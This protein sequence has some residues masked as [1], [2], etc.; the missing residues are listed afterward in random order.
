M[1]RIVDLNEVAADR[2]GTTVDEAVGDNAFDLFPPELA[3]SRKAAGDRVIASREPLRLE[4]GRAGMHFE[5]S[6]Y[7]VLDP[8][9]EVA[10]LAIFASDVTARKVAEEE[11]R[12]REDKYHTLVDTITHGVEEIDLS[13]VITFANEAYHRCSN[14]RTASLSGRRCWISVP[15]N[16]IE[17]PCETI[18]RTLRRMSPLLS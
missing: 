11:L 2:L 3:A 1:G 5:S 10:R 15:P 13:G 8:L 9:G 16:T 4:D 14:T 17:L 18:L 7:P 12:Q 6:I